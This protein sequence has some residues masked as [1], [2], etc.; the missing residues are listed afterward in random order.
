MDELTKGFCFS[1]LA[2]P[3]PML[4]TNLSCSVSYLS[5]GCYLLP[6]Q[7]L[8]PEGSDLSVILGELRSGPR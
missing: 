4:P 7:W 6:F 5:S 1:Q 3:F 8:R 2:R